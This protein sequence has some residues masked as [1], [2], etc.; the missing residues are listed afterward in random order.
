MGIL[1]VALIVIVPLGIG[2]GYFL[3]REIQKRKK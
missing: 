1:S 3:F 2:V